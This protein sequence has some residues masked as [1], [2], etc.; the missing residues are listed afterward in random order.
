MTTTLRNPLQRLVGAFTPIKRIDASTAWGVGIVA[1]SILAWIACLIVMGD[2]DQGS[3]TPLH[4]FPTF[5][6]GW[7]IMLTAMMLPSEI[8]Y[9]RVYTALLE[10]AIEKQDKHNGRFNCVTFFI[11]GYGI[12]WIGYG[13]IAYILDAI[14]RANL[15]EFIA[16]RQAGPML[17]GS[18]LFLAGVYQVSSLKHACLTHCRSPLSYFTRNWRHGYLGGLRMGLSHGFVC[19]ECCWALM[20]VMFTVGVMNLIWMGLLTLLM[21]AEKIFPFGPK[22]AIPIAAFLW[23]IGMWIAVSPETAPLLQ[24]PILCTPSIFMS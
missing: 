8:L 6:I 1:L 17:A 12:A 11:A 9:V 20:A 21:F 4:D 15:F 13:I 3:G 7:V 5:L 19:V 23:T 22:L 18:V 2:M 14:I 24:D 10:N 16:W